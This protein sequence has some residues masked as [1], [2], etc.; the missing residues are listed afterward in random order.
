MSL[1]WGLNIPP[2]EGGG[3]DE[4]LART[5]E[6]GTEGGWERMEGVRGRGAMRPSDLSRLREGRMEKR[7]L[8][9]DVWG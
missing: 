6:E 8:K 1:G 9:R 2:G 5:G 4:Y 7:D 3:G